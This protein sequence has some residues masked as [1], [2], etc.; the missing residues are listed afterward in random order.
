MQLRL[1][2]AKIAVGGLSADHFKM[3]HLLCGERVNNRG[4]RIA[5]A[6]MMGRH[7]PGNLDHR[8]KE[9]LTIPD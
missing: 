7:E 1:N 6:Q 2:A 8:G 4:R 3:Q 9:K 5:L